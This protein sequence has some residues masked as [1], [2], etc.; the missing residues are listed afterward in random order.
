MFVELEPRS[1]GVDNRGVFEIEIDAN[2]VRRLKM[3]LNGS[4]DFRPATGG[5][6]TTLFTSTQT[7]ISTVF[8]VAVGYAD[9]NTAMYYNGVQV[10]ATNTTY[11]YGAGTYATARLGTGSATP[12]NGWIRSVALF[13]TRLANATLETLTT[14]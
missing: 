6:G 5:T 1:T 4:I 10:G 12:L 7:A 13:P 11:V 8:R 14:L 2:N 3:N 9:L